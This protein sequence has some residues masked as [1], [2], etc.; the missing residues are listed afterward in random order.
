METNQTTIFPNLSF[1]LE[2]PNAAPASIH[3]EVDVAVSSSSIELPGPVQP[4]SS[5]A[6]FGGSPVKPM[7]TTSN[8][9]VT[10]SSTLSSKNNNGN[11]VFFNVE[12]N[13]FHHHH[14]NENNMIPKSSEEVISKN[15]NMPPP[16][17]DAIS[18]TVELLVN[19]AELREVALRESSVAN[20]T[21]TVR[22]GEGH[23]VFQ[24]VV[25]LHGGPFTALELGQLLLVCDSAPVVSS[26]ID[27]NG[28]D[29]GSSGVWSNI[30]ED[31]LSTLTALLRTH[32]IS[33]SGID[34]VGEGRNVIMRSMEESDNG[35]TPTITILQV[36]VMRLI[37]SCLLLPIILLIH[38]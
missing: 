31:L 8:S 14:P 17:A 20:G 23:A 2:A 12:K 7:T 35:K 16:T 4:S 21:S 18:N 5:L 1:G 27:S 10:P 28:N 3:P 15:N 26:S 13:E 9:N 34:L 25:A 30:G 29:I 37:R 19:A 38:S 33:A 24:E 22:A 32:V 6:E 36:R 11:K